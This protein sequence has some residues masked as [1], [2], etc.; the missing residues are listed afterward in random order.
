MLLQPFFMAAAMAPRL[1]RLADSGFLFDVIDAYYFYPDGVAATL[2]ARH[3][4]V[5]AVLTAYGSDINLLPHHAVPRR[6]IR[7]AAN[8]ADALTTVSQALCEELAA[9][10][11]PREKLNVI[12]NG[13]DLQLFAPP[14]DRAA[15]R[16]KL[17]LDG[18]TLLAVGNLVRLKGHELMLRTLTLVPDVRLL[19]IGSGP[20]EERLQHQARALRIADRVRFLGHVEQS[21][22]PMYY[23]AAD[24]LLHTSTSEGIPN[25][26]LEAMACGT[27]IIA[28]NVGGVPEVVRTSRVGLLIDHRDP[29][30]VAEAIRTLLAD[31]ADR[32]AIRKYACEFAWSHTAAAHVA[33][34]RNA[35]QRHASSGASS[36]KSSIK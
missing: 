1:R 10:G 30:A 19:V 11:A 7:W 20:E 27:P 29:A 8:R 26:L 9:L 34:L 13:V 31:N 35:I 33:V 28:T 4:N 2:L 22:L 18:P 32:E 5:P 16:S 21:A 23:G 17:G 6:L 3:F 36:L 15:L 24:A 14:Q 12:L 25:V